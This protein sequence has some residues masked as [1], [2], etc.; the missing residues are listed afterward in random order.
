MKKIVVNGT[1]DV[2]HIAH[3][4]MLHYAK[5]LGDYLLVCIDSDACVK[6]LKGDSRPINHQNDRA[7]FLYHIDSVDEVKVFNTQEE[8]EDILLH[9]A[10][11]VMVKGSD[12]K[13][14][15]NTGAKYCKEVIYYDRIPGYSSTQIIQNSI[16]R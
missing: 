9:Y 10:A 14:G 8:L 6:T 13:N 1:F 11:D 15:R 7:E 5:T 12:H 2:V 3:I 4:R 16:N